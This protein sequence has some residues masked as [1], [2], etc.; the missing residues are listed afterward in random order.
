M[1]SPSRRRTTAIRI[2]S[3]PDLIATTPGAWMSVPDVCALLD[4]SRS[5]IDKWRTRGVFPAGVRKPNGRVMFR[6]D[7]VAAFVD[8]LED[9]R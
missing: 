3:G 8:G 1:T 6:R 9:A 4:E 2:A 5:T 7:D